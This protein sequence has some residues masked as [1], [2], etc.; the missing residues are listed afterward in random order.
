MGVRIYVRV[1]CS[2]KLVDST[3]L[4]DLIL[5]ASFSDYTAKLQYTPTA[6]KTENVSMNT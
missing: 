6:G 5:L 1:L 2:A 4:Q 3:F